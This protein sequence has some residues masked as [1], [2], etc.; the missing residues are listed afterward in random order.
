MMSGKSRLI[1]W[2]SLRSVREMVFYSRLFRGI[3][4][5]I[6]PRSW[7][8]T[9]P[10]K[11]ENR[12]SQQ[13]NNQNRSRWV[14]MPPEKPSGIQSLKNR[15]NRGGP[16]LWTKATNTTATIATNSR[17]RGVFLHRKSRDE[18]LRQSHGRRSFTQLIRLYKLNKAKK[19]ISK[20]SINKEFEISWFQKIVKIRQVR[21]PRP[22]L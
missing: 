10:K 15:K 3:R 21:S 4:C 17:S 13:K 16:G 9:A 1:I 11:R 5:T 12:A 7:A 19:I 2:H 8:T 20:I 6:W 22:Y 18:I 14:P